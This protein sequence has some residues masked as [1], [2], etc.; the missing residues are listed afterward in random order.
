MCAVGG[1]KK[2]TSGREGVSMKDFAK[3]WTIIASDDA[4]LEEK[5]V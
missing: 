3:Y 1:E 2:G 4:G 5:E